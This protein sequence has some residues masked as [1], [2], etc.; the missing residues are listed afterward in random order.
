M[1]DLFKTIKKNNNFRKYLLYTVFAYV[2]IA[3]SLG[4]MLLDPLTGIHETVRITLAIVMF[5]VAFNLSNT[6]TKHRI[7]YEFDERFQKFIAK[8]QAIEKELEL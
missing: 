4:V 1:L 2:L 5:I 6:A 3:L 8:Y 7:Y